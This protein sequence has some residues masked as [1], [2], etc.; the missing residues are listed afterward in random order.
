VV[1]QPWVT[2]IGRG[3]SGTRAIAHTLS[4]SG[5]FMGEPLNASGDLIPPQDMYDACRVIAGHVA[6]RGGLEWDFSRLH[7]MQVPPEFARL[8]RSYLTSV[9]DHPSHRK[10]WK[11]PETTLAYPWITRMF[12]E[13]KY[14]FWVRNPRDCILGGH[15]TDDLRD[16]GVAYPPTGD[17]RLRR[18]ISWQYQYDLV[19]ATPRPANWIEVRFEDFV[20]RQDETLARLAEFLGIKLAKIPVR[21][22]AV[23]RW[24]SDGGVN[25]YDFFAPAM[26]QFGYEVP[27]GRDERQEA[28]RC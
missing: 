14:I 22:E 4:A 21:P 19:R 23:G 7:T 1:S 17:E 9:L 24:K 15:L 11:I 25:Y 27:P 10:G 28:I 5:V 2:I 8:V 16:F 20:L 26:R 18:A 13:L 3:H 12:P 6:W